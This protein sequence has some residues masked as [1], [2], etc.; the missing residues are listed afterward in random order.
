LI[1]KG[2]GISNMVF[3]YRTTL[4]IPAG[5]DPPAAAAA[6]QSL[7][8]AITR[9]GDLAGAAQ[10]AFVRGYVGVLIVSMVI[11]AVCAVTAR[12]LFGSLAT[13]GEETEADAPLESSRQS[14]LG[15]P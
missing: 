9:G 13:M 12:T 11:M 3:V 2:C 7:A 1:N 10:D 4:A 6:R 14:I 5:A 8:E 15:R